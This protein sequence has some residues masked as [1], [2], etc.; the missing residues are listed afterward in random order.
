LTSG[1]GPATFKSNE[2]SLPASRPSPSSCAKR[3]GGCVRC[4]EVTNA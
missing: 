3:V 2:R 1:G 4:G